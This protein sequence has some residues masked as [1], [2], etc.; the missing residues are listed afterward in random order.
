MNKPQSGQS[1]S[2]S[3][4]LRRPLTE[5]TMPATRNA[6]LE[7]L[8]TAQSTPTEQPRLAKWRD[9]DLRSKVAVR[10]K[11]IKSE[12]AAV[13]SDIAA[14][15]LP[16]TKPLDGAG[17]DGHNVSHALED[18]TSDAAKAARDYRSWMFEHMQSNINTAL[19]YA[20]GL[21]TMSLSARLDAF[22]VSRAHEQRKDPGISKPEKHFSVSA[23]IAAE[24]CAKSFELMAAHVTNTFEYA[25]R[26]GDI[27]SPAEFVVLSTGQV[28][29]QVDLAMLYR[30][31]LRT[32]SQSSALTDAERLNAG[33]AKVPTGQE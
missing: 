26:L 10:R 8:S 3:R 22:S 2:G 23:N 4:R 30:A 13:A 18:V 15:R 17:L 27:K 19:G 20:S 11:T 33:I 5:I 32:L 16:Q 14:R 7:K 25:Q 9:K 1:A 28:R 29:N 12:H 24:L 31:A 21:A 6:V